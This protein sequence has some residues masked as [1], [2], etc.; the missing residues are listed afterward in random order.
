M[1]NKINNNKMVLYKYIFILLFFISLNSCT[2]PN[3]SIFGCARITT[4]PSIPLQQLLNSPDNLYIDNNKLTM[5]VTLSISSSPNLA[6]CMICY[7]NISD[8]KTNYKLPLSYKIEK[9]WLI[10][11][12]EIWEVNSSSINYSDP[13]NIMILGG[14]NWNT[15]NQ[16]AIIKLSDINGKSF[17]IKSNGIDISLIA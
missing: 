8:T 14:P 5:Q 1:L 9:F 15:Y 11:N 12:K 16:S 4:N 17:F 6:R 10:N 13:G 2:N 7:I 3:S